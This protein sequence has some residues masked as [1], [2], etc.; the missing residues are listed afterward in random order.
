ML[1][2][3]H[4]KL[5]KSMKMK[6]RDYEKVIG[7][8]DLLNN[9]E[10]LEKYSYLYIDKFDIY[11]NFELKHVLSSYLIEKL[12]KYALC[13]RIATRTLDHDEKWKI[14][15]FSYPRDSLKEQQEREFDI[16]VIIKYLEGMLVTEYELIF[17]LEKKPKEVH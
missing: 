17:S 15:T 11:V 13:N 9:E 8:C 12:N 5:K 4:V 7:R 2:Y 16:Q 6:Y 14:E 1:F 3:Y 10:V